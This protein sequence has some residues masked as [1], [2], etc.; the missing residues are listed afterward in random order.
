VPCN[1]LESLW[2]ALDGSY[3]AATVCPVNL[4][5]LHPIMPMPLR[6]WVLFSSLELNEALTACTH[7]S[8]PSPDHIM[9]SYLKYWC[10]SKGIMSLFMHGPLAP[11]L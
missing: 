10:G 3:N 8:S 2:D 11:T 6:E 9:W 4:S 5:F 7:N 1:S